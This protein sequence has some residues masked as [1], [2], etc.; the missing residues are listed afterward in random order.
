MIMHQAPFV[1]DKRY[2]NDKLKMNN[3]NNDDK[4][5]TPTEMEVAL[6]YKLLTLQC[7][8]YRAFTVY[9]VNTVCYSNC[10]ILLKQ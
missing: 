6:R 3:S 9:T 5:K 8:A 2:K 1:T 10:F 4:K 7:T